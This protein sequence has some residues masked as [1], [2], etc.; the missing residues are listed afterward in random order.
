[1]ADE[2]ER[3]FQQLV[4]VLADRDPKRLSTP[5]Q[6][7]ELYQEFVPYR[8]YRATLRFDTNQD[9]EM[10]VLR[11]LAGEHGFAS[12]SPTEVQEAM[13]A[14]ATASNP[15]T[16]AFR[17]FAAATV[18]L[19]AE[20]VR[21]VLDP[22]DRY[23]PP[24]PVTTP[25]TEPPP[26]AVLGE[27]EQPTEQ[28]LPRES[29]PFSPPTEPARG[30]VQ[31]VGKGGTI[32]EVAAGAAPAGP[33]ASDSNSCPHCKTTLPTRRAVTYC[34]QCGGQVRTDECARCGAKVE[35]DWHHCVVCGHRMTGSQ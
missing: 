24:G 3:L 29:K 27:A 34:P 23:R 9:Y 11:L 5:F 25:V 6:I 26:V 8:T 15:D 12:V 10:A 20:A 17:D 22:Q 7:S 32:F 1:M 16:D 19:N 14:E 21:A 31:V 35:S 2:V 33:L 4:Q 13:L 28:S 30:P 18:T